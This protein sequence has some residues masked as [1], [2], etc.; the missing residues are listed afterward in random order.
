[1]VSAIRVAE[2]RRWH[3]WADRLTAGSVDRYVCVSE[4]VARFSAAQGGL[5]AKKL[6][7]IPNGIDAD[8]F[9][10]RSA[11]EPAALGSPVGR[12]L[13]TYV[14]RLDRQK[15]VRWLVEAAA[16]WLGRL[17]DCDLLLVG[18]GPERRRLERLCG[19]QGISDRVR[20]AGWRSDVAEILAGS[21]LLVLPS[22]WEGMPNVVLQ[23][24]ASRLPVLASDV[25]G[26]RELLGPDSEPQTVRYGD[27]DALV[28][29]IVRL[30]SDREFA[31]EL[32]ARNRQ[33]ARQEFTIERVVTA[34]EGLW[35]SL[36]AE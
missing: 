32:G 7:V 13:V 11:A 14:G 1:M 23:A 26:V 30:M 29:K 15:G 31:G 25:E 19:K 33:R 27:S 35:A 16:G 21:Q 3:L 17:P 28:E 12:R 5:P 18:E 6:V 10:A 24:M 8:Q 34:Y 36:V 20:F 4:A 2:P 9:S 22:R